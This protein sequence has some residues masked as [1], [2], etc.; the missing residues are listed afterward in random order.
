MSCEVLSIGHK[1]RLL[2]GD[3]ACALNHCAT[4]TAPTRQEPLLE[5]VRK[6]RALL[7]HGV[8]RRYEVQHYVTSVLTVG[9]SLLT[10]L[11]TWF[12]LVVPA[13]VDDGGECTVACIQLSFSSAPPMEA[14]LVYMYTFICFC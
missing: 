6:S 8:C 14:K 7:S 3:H 5:D 13:D 11:L 12:T 10:L 9:H 4:L 1:G 2:L